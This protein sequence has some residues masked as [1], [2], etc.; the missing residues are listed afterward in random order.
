MAAVPDGAGPGPRGPSPTLDWPLR[1]VPDFRR[2][3]CPPT[4]PW[5]PGPL[6]SG[7][8]PL[9]AGGRPWLGIG[10]CA[11]VVPRLLPGMRRTRTCQRGRVSLSRLPGH[12]AASRRRQPRSRR[13]R[14]EGTAGIAPRSTEVAHITKC[15]QSK[16]SSENLGCARGIPES[17]MYTSRQA[18]ARPERPPRSGER[19]DASAAGQMT[20]TT[21]TA[22]S[23]RSGL[24]PG[25]GAAVAINQLPVPRPRTRQEAAKRGTEFW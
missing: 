11:R 8:S 23:A 25:G 5:V 15:L 21:M 4:L 19:R 9:A 24:E 16:C 22:P 1:T 20:R 13:A 14:Y 6:G 18:R 12:A 10:A 17:E 7:V 3:F 2:F